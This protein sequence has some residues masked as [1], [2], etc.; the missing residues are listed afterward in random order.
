MASFHFHTKRGVK[1]SKR[2][3]GKTIT[4]ARAHAS[5]IAREGQYKNFRGEEELAHKEYGN[6]PKWAT[7]NPSIFWRMSDLHERQ[8][9]TTFREYEVALPR[10]LT[11]A[12]RV[13]LVREF[14]H[15]EFGER[16]A[17][18]WAIH[19]PNA[20][21]DGEEQPHAHIMFSERITDG[22]ERDPE[23][24]F[25]RSNSKNPAL[26]GCKKANTETRFKAA[27]GEEL[28]ALRKRWADIQN[29]HLEQYGHEDRVD[30]RTLRAQ[31]IDRTP[32]SH[33]GPELAR[34][35]EIKLGL[36]TRRAANL[37]FELGIIF[38]SHAPVKTD[39]GND[40]DEP[41][42]VSPVRPSVQLDHSLHKQMSAKTKH[43]P[44]QVEQWCRDELLKKAMEKEAL[45]KTTIPA[46]M[47]S[48]ESKK[49]DVPEALGQPVIRGSRK[50]L[51][52]DT[53][54]V[55]E[56][57]MTENPSILKGFF[58][59]KDNLVQRKQELIGQITT[60][61]NGSIYIKL[62][63]QNKDSTLTVIGHG[64][65]INK[66]RD[67]RPVYFDEYAF[68]I[69]GSTISCRVNSKIS[70]GLRDK[71][72]FESSRIERHTSPIEPLV[73]ELAVN[74]IP[75]KRSRPH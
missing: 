49:T 71:L 6:M 56:L 35:S 14:V 60:R 8:N 65:A 70:E 20:A 38:K 61:E 34:N 4:K 15:Q 54:L 53:V 18:L 47:P 63:T 2:G 1:S 11:P 36:L 66:H 68:N 17:Y 75:T 31:G 51:K 22:I 42:Y 26:G 73:P 32:E 58:I 7:R 30:H 33:L 41:M 44:A 37:K 64:N 10:E 57:C 40:V 5:Y 21:I 28:V 67:G 55:F 27:A 46:K 12:Q 43:T 25:S 50:T 59:P 48:S 74:P 24:Y 3:T 45:E 16:H 13:E 29:R 72:G 69:E 9:G 62:S 52:G 39:S 19:V 23:Q